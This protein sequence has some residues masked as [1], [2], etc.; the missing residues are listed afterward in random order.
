MESPLGPIL[1]NIFMDELERSVIPGI[2]NKLNNCKRHVDDT[3]CYIKADT[4]NYVIS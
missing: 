2:T 1:A 4:I 3:I